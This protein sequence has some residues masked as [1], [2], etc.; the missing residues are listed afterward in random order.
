MKD[1]NRITH[2]ASSSVGSSKGNPAWTGQLDCGIFPSGKLWAW[3]SLILKINQQLKVLS[4]ELPMRSTGLE[5]LI[6]GCKHG[7]QTPEA[8][9]SSMLSDLH[10][11]IRG[12]HDAHAM[13]SE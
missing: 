2:N 5:V 3:K 11:S 10:S 9:I 7:P 13:Q 8:G 1:S 12:R 4:L 6:D